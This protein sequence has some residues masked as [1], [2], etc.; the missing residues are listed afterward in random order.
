MNEM[1]AGERP[2]T[3][4]LEQLPCKWFIQYQDKSGLAQDKPSEVILKKAFATFGDVRMVDIPM[5]DPYRHKMKAGVSGIKTFSFGQDLVFDAYIQFKEYIGFVKAMNALRGMKLCYQDRDTNKA[6]T[7]NIR[8][9]FDKTK[10]LSEGMI[11]KRKEERERLIK[12]E[13]EKEEN[14]K[15]RSKLES[16]QKKEQIKLLEKEEKEQEEKQAA[17]RLVAEQRRLAR[18]EKRKQKRLKKMGLTEEE[19]IAYRIGAEERKLLLA[20]RKLESIRVLDELLGR[21]KVIMVTLLL[22]LLSHIRT[23]GGLFH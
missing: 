23:I 16:L 2:D 10:H 14:E 17:K 6:W 11:K 4:H 12:E 3:I 19:E 18:E 9:D 1:K 13:A 5:L 15:M 20:Q 22:L 21:V 7:A 8:V